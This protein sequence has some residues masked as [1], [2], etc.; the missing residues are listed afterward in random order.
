MSRSSGSSATKAQS[1]PTLSSSEPMPESR[2]ART[3]KR[4]PTPRLQTAAQSSEDLDS[5]HSVIDASSPQVLSSAVTERRNSAGTPDVPLA[6]ASALRLVLGDPWTA[7][8]LEEAHLA[9]VIST[10]S[11]NQSVRRLS[12]AEGRIQ[13]IQSASTSR[14]L[15][16]SASCEAIPPSKGIPAQ[17]N[18]ATDGSPMPGSSEARTRESELLQGPRIA[19]QLDSRHPSTE[20]DSGYCS[21][22]DSVEW[23]DSWM[24]SP[25]DSQQ[26]GYSVI[27]RRV[28]AGSTSP[29][30]CNKLS[31]VAHSNCVRHTVSE[32]NSRSCHNLALNKNGSSFLLVTSRHILE[33]TNSAAILR[34]HRCHIPTKIPRASSAR[35]KDTCKLQTLISSPTRLAARRTRT[36]E[37]TQNSERRALLRFPN[38]VDEAHQHGDTSGQRACNTNDHS[39]SRF[40][41]SA[42]S[43][44]LQ[45]DNAHSLRRY[46]AWELQGSQPSIYSGCQ[47]L[48]SKCLARDTLP[49]STPQLHMD[50]TDHTAIF[51]SNCTQDPD[52][53]LTGCSVMPRACKSGTSVLAQVPRHMKEP[54]YPVIPAITLRLEASV[55]PLEACLA[56]PT[57]ASN[58]R[59]STYPLDHESDSSM[60]VEPRALQA[61]SSDSGAYLNSSRIQAHGKLATDGSP[62]SS[63]S[64]T[65]TCKS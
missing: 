22:H 55:K 36:K 3:E 10:M 23:K 32:S 42:N 63:S 20:K 47:L 33:R 26:N 56:M 38:R 11:M 13:G 15:P 34:F 9:L 27:P 50:P 65:R 46:N 24:A 18:S 41:Y 59:A 7:R 44:H 16:D 43:R 49:P 54:A 60:D 39:S 1:L 61:K 37:E 62:M 57:R 6:R 17:G 14:L 28:E 53:S 25:L 31:T 30:S 5:I 51:P 21:V 48:S 35:P 40:P 4:L 19:G 8:V 29:S 12:N 2:C 45:S 64:D 52:R 58:A